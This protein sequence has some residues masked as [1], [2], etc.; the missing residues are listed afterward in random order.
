MILPVKVTIFLLSTY[1][2][3]MEL[4]LLATTHRD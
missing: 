4:C 1:I 2:I 3:P